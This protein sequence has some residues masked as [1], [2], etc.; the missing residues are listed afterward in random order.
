CRKPPPFKLDRTEVPKSRVAASTVIEHL[1]VV[2]DSGSMLHPCH[3]SLPVEKFCLQRSEET[4]C[5]RIVVGVSDG[6]HRTYK[7]SFTYGFSKGKRGVLFSHRALTHGPADDTPRESVNDDGEVQPALV[8]VLLRHIGHPQLIGPLCSKR[9]LY[10]VWSGRTSRVSVRD[11]FRAPAAD[12]FDAKLSHEASH[13]FLSASNVVDV[14]QL[15][16]NARRTVG[17]SAQSVD[18]HDVFFEHLVLLVAP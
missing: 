10:E 18:T 3:P 17:A 2:E 8:G 6:S 5:H 1:D 16:M 12:A 14:P 15:R 13:A 4:L 11:P 7:P 9:P